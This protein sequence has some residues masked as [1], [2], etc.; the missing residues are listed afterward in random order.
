MTTPVS[1]ITVDR[2]SL[3]SGNLSHD[4]NYASVNVGVNSPKTFPTSLISDALQSSELKPMQFRCRV[5]SI[6]L[7]SFIYWSSLC[8][9]YVQSAFDSSIVSLFACTL[10]IIS[11]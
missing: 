3:M 2:T 4:L 6:I 5:I 7:I 8:S 1:F 10:S 11:G 9:V